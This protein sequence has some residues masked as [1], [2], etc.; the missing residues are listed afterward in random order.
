MITGPSGSGKSTLARSILGLWPEFSGDIS[1]GGQSLYSQ[2]EF[3][4]TSS[5]GYLPQEVNLF[6]GSIAEN[7]SR[8]SSPI[9]ANKV[10]EAAKSSHVHELILNFPEGYDTIVGPNGQF[11]SG[12]Q[13]QRLG[14]ARAIYGNPKVVVLDE[15]N[16]NLDDDGINALMKTLERLK[17][18]LVTV[19]VI[20]HRPGIEKIS[21]LHLNITNSQVIATKL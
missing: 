20:S 8:F 6:D 9:D 11:L 18:N 2:A 21:D 10:I 13:L 7:I 4:L 3:D 12:G 1:I 5:M 14:L 15:P 16:A 17:K 19:I